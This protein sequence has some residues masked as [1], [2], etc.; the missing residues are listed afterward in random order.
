MQP[1]IAMVLNQLV[2]IINRPNT[3]KT[4]LENTG[5]Q[6]CAPY[7]LLMTDTFVTCLMVSM[8][9][10]QPS[11]SADWVTF[12]LRR[13]PPCCRS[14]SDPG[15]ESSP[16][17]QIAAVRKPQKSAAHC[18]LVDVLQVH[19]SPQHPRQRGERLCLSWDLHNDRCESRR[20]GAGEASSAAAVR[21]VQLPSVEL[22]LLHLFL[23]LRIS[24]S[25]VT[26]WPP[27]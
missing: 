21:V 25:S 2:E 3:P 26:L 11:P 14:L 5:M 23:M 1:Y 27:G 7:V 16:F 22:H 18:F 19:I 17:T 6:T 15:G 9:V 12:A 24:S 8:L 13:L 4:L 20:R 10:L